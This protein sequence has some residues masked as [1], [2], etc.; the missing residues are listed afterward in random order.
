MKKEKPNIHS[1]ISYELIAISKSKVRSDW[2]ARHREIEIKFSKLKREWNRFESEAHEQYHSWY[3]QTFAQELNQIREIDEESHYIR[4]V[5]SA[6]ESQMIVN[7]LTK[8]AAFEYVMLAYQN[9]TDP[10]PSSEEEW[11]YEKQEAP[12]RIEEIG[13]SDEF[14]EFDDQKIAV[15][16]LRVSDQSYKFIYRKIVSLLHPDRGVEMNAMEKVLWEQTQSAYLDRDSNL[17]RTILLRIEGTSQIELKS[18]ETIGTIQTMCDALWFEYEEIKNQQIIAKNK[19]VYQFYS[20]NKK[21][22]SLASI[23]TELSQI[24]KQELFYKN[25]ILRDLKSSFSR[26][27]RSLKK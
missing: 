21:A 10:F 12:Y 23:K 8:R 9:K 24:L 15:T 3:H 5:L 17:L 19:P 22:K 1:P 18:I 11:E 27:E 14:V 2:I 6:I 26:F 13:D 25:K 4:M 16:E 20:L 7:Q